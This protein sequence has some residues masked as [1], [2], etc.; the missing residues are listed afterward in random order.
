MSS[1]SSIPT[2]L[3]RDYPAGSLIFEENEPGSRMYVIRSGRVKIF[4][5]VGNQEIVL[6]TLGAGDFFGEMALLEN[7]PRSASAQT[8]D[9]SS[10]I[11]VDAQTFAEMVRRNA[12]IAIRIMRRLAGRVRELDRRLQNLV[13]D[14]GVG[15]ALEVL[16][17]L[18]ARGK[19]EGAFVRVPSATVHVN[20][21][22]QAGVSPGEVEK[23]LRR[24]VS[25]GCIREEGADILIAKGEVLDEYS[26]F[27]D[28][29]KKYDPDHGHAP[30]EHHGK[31]ED[32]QK[33]M[34]RL[35]KALQIAPEDLASNQTVL[36]TQYRK[37][38]ALKTRYEADKHTEG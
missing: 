5:K 25:A 38:L 18:M 35:L 8:V 7:L 9:P 10:L 20:I 11:E 34:Q 36:S 19:P 33:A 31:K 4:R 32:T 15:R 3:T 27:L 30:M 2:S 37:Y 26:S 14:S 28:L 29:K 12:E 21:T 23:I 6:A 13:L 16:R 17:W 1:D 24:L 22:A